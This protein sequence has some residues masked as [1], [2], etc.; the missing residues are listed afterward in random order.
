MDGW[1]AG[2]SQ[3]QGNNGGVLMAARN[4]SSPRQMPVQANS[5]RIARVEVGL[6]VYPSG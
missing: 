5:P 1:A 2:D 6:L 3:D 4:T